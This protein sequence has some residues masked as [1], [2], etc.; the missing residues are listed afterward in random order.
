MAHSNRD[1]ANTFMNKLFAK[2]WLNQRK[3]NKNGRASW[4]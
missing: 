1:T 2:A 3:A 4:G